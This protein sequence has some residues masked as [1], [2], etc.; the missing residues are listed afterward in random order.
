VLKDRPD[1][2]VSEVI[3]LTSEHQQMI[4]TLRH[5]PV[6]AVAH[7]MWYHAKA[8]EVAA[9]LFYSAGGWRSFLPAAKAAKPGS[10]PE[11]DLHSAGESFGAALP[12]G[13]REARGLQ[14]FLS[15]PAVHRETGKTIFQYLRQLRMGRAAELLKEGRLN[16][17]QVSLEVGYT[18]P[19][20]FS[21][22]FHETFG[23][24]PGLYPLA[25]TTQQFAE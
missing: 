17:T 5:P 22:A 14:P 15:Q 21:M 20:H 19:S 18:S 13:D 23:C 9:A 25:T 1:P 8:L 24:C 7:R 6:T 3:R 12:G 4:T 11:S 2:E 10:D 16:V